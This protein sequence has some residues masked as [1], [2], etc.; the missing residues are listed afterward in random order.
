MRIFIFLLLALVYVSSANHVYFSPGSAIGKD[1]YAD[2]FLAGENFGGVGQIFCGRIEGISTWAAFIK[3]EELN[4]SQYQG[5]T[6]LDATLSLWVYDYDGP[7]Q[8]Q[9][10]SCSSFWDEYSLTWNNMPSYHAT[11]YYDYPTDM[12]FMLFDATD[13]VQNWLDGTW[14]NDGFG[15]FDVD[16]AYET[17][18][19]RSR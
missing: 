4:D 8:F 13:W 10:A 15:F 6:V 2:E 18:A 17:V 1:C 16:A 19:F 14:D 5:A 11:V 3:F 7:G 9:F 12:G